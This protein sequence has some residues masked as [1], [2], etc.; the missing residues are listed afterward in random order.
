MT[1]RLYTAAA[2][3][4][5]GAAIG[6]GLAMTAPGSAQ[7]AGVTGPALAP[8]AAVAQADP[9][10][11]AGFGMFS[12]ARVI[13]TGYVWQMQ[14]HHERH[15]DRLHR[16]DPNRFANRLADGSKGWVDGCNAGWSWKPG[17]GWTYNTF[18]CDQEAVLTGQSK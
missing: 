5:I 11:T 13:E 18:P 4:A 3:A 2:V 8:I 7:A 12:G 6:V 15:S 1:Y 10:P 17:S 9:A 16:N 14:H